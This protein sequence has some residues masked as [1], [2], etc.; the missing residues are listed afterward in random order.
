MTKWRGRRAC[1]KYFIPRKAFFASRDSSCS[2]CSDLTLAVPICNSLAIVF[3]LTVGKVL[4][5]D[6]GGKGKL[7]G[8]TSGMAVWALAYMNISLT[9][10]LGWMRRSLPSCC[11][12]FYHSSPA[13]LWPQSPYPKHSGGRGW[14]E[15]QDQGSPP[16]HLPWP[17]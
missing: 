5:E 1:C 4:G 12:L 7:S 10:S 13:L 8:C 17:H 11:P 9:I 6:I 3:T 2:A 16:S 14:D 15:N